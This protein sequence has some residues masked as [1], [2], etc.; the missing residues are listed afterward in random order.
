MR[1][2]QGEQCFVV[3][4]ASLGSLPITGDVTLVA[5][6]AQCAIVLV[7]L[8]VAGHAVTGRI[9]EDQALVATLAF[10]LDVLTQQGELGLV[11]V[12]LALIVPTTL[13]VTRRAIAPQATLVL[14]VLLMTTLAIRCQLLLVQGAG[15][16]SLALG[17]TVL[18]VERV[19]GVHIVIEHAGLP[20]ACVV[21]GL[22]LLT[23]LSLMASPPLDQIR[24][25]LAVASKAIARRV[26]IA[27]ILMASTAL[28]LCVLVS[29][30]KPR[31]GMIERCLLPARLIVAIGA[32][33][34]QGPLVHIAVFVAD[35]TISRC[36]TPFSSYHMAGLAV[37]G[38]MLP[39]Q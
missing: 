19:L 23:K 6:L 10:D 35:R 39:R 29:Q 31:L 21:T 15:V 1:I 33:T 12:E 14:V 9:L 4:E 30:V 18:A 38:Y 8:Q 11:V 26:L 2:A 36:F 24:V 34:A 32:L 27:L 16:T 5:G 22:A 28:D 20:A 7:I 3:I 13:V 37:D 25:V 17:M